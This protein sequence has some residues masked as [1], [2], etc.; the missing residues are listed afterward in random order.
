MT[1]S[2]AAWGEA[3]E[4]FLP[5]VQLLSAPTCRVCSQKLALSG[6]DSICSQ[7]RCRSSCGRM[8]CPLASGFER[9]ATAWMCRV[10][11]SLS[12]CYPV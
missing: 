5:S 11:A 8:C 1:R 4:L 3:P 6:T 7:K 12:R 10:L 9:E 2:K